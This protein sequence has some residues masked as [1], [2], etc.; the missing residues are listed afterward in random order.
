MFLRNNEVL[1]RKVKLLRNEV[2]LRQMKFATSGELRKK[3]HILL[4]VS[5]ERVEKVDT[6]QKILLRAIFFVNVFP[7]NKV[8]I[9]RARGLRAPLKSA[10]SER[11]YDC[12][13]D[14]IRGT[15]F[16]EPFA[17]VRKTGFFTVYN[18]FVNF[19]DKTIN[20]MLYCSYML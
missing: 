12:P 19:V 6:Q 13:S 1:L 20:A 3:G 18:C 11:Q 16:P 2:C 8:P 17:V 10:L 4:N 9:S 15:F 5:F 7:R 14:F